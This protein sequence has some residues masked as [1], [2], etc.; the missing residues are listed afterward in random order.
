M[1]SFE[2]NKDISIVVPVYNSEAYLRECLDSLV[3]QTI[4]ERLE[5]LLIDDGSTDKSCDI[6]DEYAQNY[7]ES[8]KVF[9]KRNGGSASARQIG[10]DNASS[11]WII[12]CDSDDFVD[13]EMYET[14]LNEAERQ[15]VDIVMCDLAYEYPDGKSIPTRKVFNNHEP[16]SLTV[17]KMILADSSNSSSCTKLIRRELF[18]RNALSWEKDINLGEDTL[19]IL[20]LLHAEPNIRIS[21][22]D[23]NF[24]HYRRRIGESTY[25]NFLTEDKWEQLSKV[26]NWKRENLNDDELNC[27]VS[28]S[29]VDLIFAYLRVQDGRR[30]I[31]EIDNISVK[32]ILTAK[33]PFLKRAVV[34][35]VKLFGLGIIRP[36]FNRVY[37][38]F[39]K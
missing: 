6:C 24:Y 32:E 39:Y 5:I 18:E 13:S 34:L 25:T 20:K 7:P 11:E 14:M 27:F 15:H 4:F 29:S 33:S 3:A 36:M 28:A 23:E 2:N 37:P 1:S 9:H 12:V 17:I 8:F 26:H 35:S 38:L 31:N 30:K 22:I 10:W 19:M 21:K 16:N